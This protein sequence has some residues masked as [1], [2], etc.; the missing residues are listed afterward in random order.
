MKGRK[1][2]SPLIKKKKK[3]KTNIRLG[4]WPS[5]RIFFPSPFPIVLD[6]PPC[7]YLVFR[8]CSP[9]SSRLTSSSLISSFSS[10][11]P[12]ARS[13]SLSYSIPLSPSLSFS[14][15]NASFLPLCN[16][17]QRRRLEPYVSMDELQKVPNRGKAVPQLVMRHPRWQSTARVANTVE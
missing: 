11:Q 10:L 2:I 17:W 6:L 13:L 1:G 16:Q 5:Q 15:L 12:L 14:L 9:E 3:K 7:C 4:T 8:R